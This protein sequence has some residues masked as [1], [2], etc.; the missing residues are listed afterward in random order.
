MGRT[1]FASLPAPCR[2]WPRCSACLLSSLRSSGYLT[3]ASLRRWPAKR[4]GRRPGE[5]PAC[6]SPRGFHVNSNTPTDEYL[7]PLKLT[8][9]SAGAWRADR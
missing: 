2:C 4:N 1:A 5:D 3:W 6:P 9:T 8:S 7:I